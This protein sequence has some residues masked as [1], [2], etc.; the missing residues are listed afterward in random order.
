MKKN[1]KEQLVPTQREL[2]VFSDELL[3]EFQ[4]METYGGVDDTKYICDVKLNCSCRKV[5]CGASTKCHC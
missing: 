3:N 4:M 5:N 1:E 2:E